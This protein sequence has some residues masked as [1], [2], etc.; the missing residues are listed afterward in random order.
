VSKASGM[1]RWSEW[2]RQL[3]SRHQRA[4]ARSGEAAMVFQ[5][6]IGPRSLFRSTAVTY[7]HLSLHA[8]VGIVRRP[9]AYRPLQAGLRPADCASVF[10]MP[11]SGP[12]SLP[13]AP[14]SPR[15]EMAAPR[16]GLFVNPGEPTHPANTLCSS[17][18]E[19]IWLPL[20]ELATRWRTK[21]AVSKQ[22]AVLPMCF[23]QRA[24]RSE[25]APAE[26]PRMV[27]PVRHATPM[28]ARVQ[29]GDA[30]FAPWWTIPSAVQQPAPSINVDALTSQVM[31]QIDRR[32]VAYRERM[33]RV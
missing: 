4:Q 12:A 22:A 28:E 23:R 9:M 27:S 26:L 31:Q 33:G 5:R 25:R 14:R 30:Q 11:R 6:A 3:R 32:F 19:R 1:N 24:T 8:A 7:I 13:A 17:S 20:P 10:A 15:S 29:A 18:L 16:Q 21:P 2:A